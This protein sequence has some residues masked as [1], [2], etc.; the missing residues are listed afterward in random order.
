MSS[1]QCKVG[2]NSQNSRVWRKLPFVNSLESLSPLDANSP[3]PLHRQL[4][5]AIQRLLANGVWVNTSPIPS[6]REMT[7]TLGISRATVRQAIQ[8]LELEGWLQRQQG[9]GTFAVRERI[10]QPLEGIT[11]FSQNMKLLGLEAH[12]RLISAKLEPAVPRVAKA[13]RL[14]VGAPVA[15]VVRLRLAGGEPLM[16]ERAHLNYGLVPNILEHN[17][18]GSLYDILTKTYRLE[19]ALGEETVEAI[20]ANSRLAKSLEIKP[21]DP[22]LH[23]QRTVFTADGTALE[24]TERFGRAD[25]C[26]FKVALSG[27]NTQIQ[28][29]R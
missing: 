17:L 25:K 3:V 1:T 22:V 7:Q 10:E 12:S 18:R 24:Y 23:T 8:T 2:K 6:E 27:N 15:V 5:D 28:L 4:R 13:L 11:G 16:L 29:T 21:N 9:R 20:I 26:S 19:F 14:P